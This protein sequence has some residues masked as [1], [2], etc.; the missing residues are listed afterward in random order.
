MFILVST[1][2]VLQEQMLLRFVVLNLGEMS[3]CV[4]AEKAK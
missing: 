2:Q 1:S 3:L 4:K